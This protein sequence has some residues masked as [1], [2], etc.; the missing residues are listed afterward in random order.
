[1]DFYKVKHRGEKVLTE[2]L[3]AII[4]A[5]GK[6]SRFNTSLTKLSFTICGQEMIAYPLRLLSNLS[7]KSTLVVGYQKEVLLD[8]IKK[9][10]YSCEYVEQSQQKGTGHA[11]LCSKESW[12][13]ENILILNA[14]VPLLNED[15]LISL[16]EKH[17]SSDATIT[18]AAAYN[19]DPSVTGYGRIIMEDGSLSIV[20]QRDFT[21]DP[22][23]HCR[24]NAGIYLIKRSFLEAELPHLPASSSGEF[25][26]TDLIKK[27]SKA[28][29][30]VEI[31]DLPFDYVRGVNTLKELW[32]A[33]HIK[34]SDIIAHWMNQGVRFAAPQ[35]V[36]IDLNV[37]L[38]ADSF[39]GYGVQLRNG[40]KIGCSVHID[41]FS[42]I[43][44][45]R[46]HDGAIIYSHSVVQ[47]AEVH[48]A[49]QIGPFAHIHKESV[50]YPQS[51]VGNFV[52]VSKSTIGLKTKAKHL[53]YIGNAEVGAHA[54]IGAGTITCNY[55]GVSK[56]VT[57]IKDR[58]FVGVNT[59]LI[60]P[61]T[62]GEGAFIAAGS[63]ITQDVPEDAL[64]IARM[65][66]IN[67]EQYASK[68]K[69]RYVQNQQHKTAKQE[70]SVAFPPKNAK[71]LQSTQAS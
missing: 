40:T 70:D 15:H 7:I 54:N 28:G 14:D 27:A 60:A 4:L 44:N 43:D 17:S 1:M 66:Q 46:I 49:S 69:E 58:A 47:N 5:A 25:Y 64:A 12:A 24:L 71:E 51:V 41:A 13:A 26:I 59:S 29:E 50:L 37:T 33:E 20:E 8:I 18:F 35:S 3:Q 22:S 52:E 39:I 62:I 16:I 6:S 10:N 68:L 42:I 23:S 34:K 36:H 56:H 9:Y 45:A 65:E 53:A 61:V 32:V 57:T 48:T 38:D 11:V 63:V 67:K 2:K 55:N 19:A 31:V 21:G 30:R